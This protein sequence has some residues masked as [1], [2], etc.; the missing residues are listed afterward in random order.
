MA[1][2]AAR[3][4]D[5]LKELRDGAPGAREQLFR[6][7]YQELRRIASAHMR[8]EPTGHTLQPT[9]LVHE[10]YLKLL[11][12]EG[13]RD[14]A[15]FLVAASRSMREILVDHARARAALRRGG[16]RGRVTLDEGIDAGRSPTDELLAVHDALA[17]LEAIDPEWSRVVE[18]RYFGGLTF[19]EAAEGMGVS[20]RTTKRLWERA[21]TWLLR[22][23]EK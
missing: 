13:W 5:V 9:A 8:R 7:V 21:R 4:T 3:V 12:E 1:E 2:P 10:A 6:L 17:R 11:G 18:L 22:E 19:E 15:H 23:I 16:G 14:R 20:V